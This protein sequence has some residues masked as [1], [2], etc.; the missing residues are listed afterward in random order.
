MVNAENKRVAEERLLQVG[1]VDLLVFTDGSAVE[2][3]KYGGAGVVIAKG[4]VTEPE[5][6]EEMRL[7]AGRATSSFQA[8]MVALEAAL[9]RVEEWQEDWASVLVVADSQANL[10]AVRDTGSGRQEE[11]VR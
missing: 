4:C 5:V 9:R 8:E 1:L 6:V 7:A 3:V 11:L 2:G 10:M